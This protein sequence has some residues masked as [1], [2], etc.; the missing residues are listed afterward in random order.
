MSVIFAPTH[1]IGPQLP[2]VDINVRLMC[3]DCR[4]PVPN[5]VEDFAAGDLICGNCGKK[6]TKIIFHVYKLEDNL[7]DPKE[8]INEAIYIFTYICTYFSGL[9][10]GNRIIDTRSEWR[11]F[12]NSDENGDD[13]SR[14][15]NGTNHLLGSSHLDSTIISNRGTNPSTRYLSRTHDRVVEMKAERALLSHFKEIQAMCDRIGTGGLVSDSAKQLFKKVEDGKIFKNRNNEEAVMAACIFIACRENSVGRTFREIC[16]LSRISKR[17][18]ARCYKAIQPIF[19]GAI[20]QGTID[21][22]VSR[23]ASVLSLSPESVKY[24]G[25]LARIAQDKGPLSGKSPITI[26]ATCLYLVS[27][28]SST[29]KTIKEISDI[30]QC[31]EATLRSAYKSLW[32]KRMEMIPSHFKSVIPIRNLPMA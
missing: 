20:R 4:D 27:Q 31:S 8:D 10:L 9:I 21:S 22:Y 14:V 1:A 5:I 11:T 24:T 13:P 19:D 17:E 18:I 3:A 15:G 2:T 6:K 30:A 7:N 28:M 12:A 32:E 25:E 16:A 26:V 23:F 29:P